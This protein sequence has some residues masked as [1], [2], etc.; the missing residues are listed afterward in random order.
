M[1]ERAATAA[2]LRA[3]DRDDDSALQRIYAH[4]VLTGLASF[5]EIPPDVGEME[6]RRRAVQEDGLPY[7]VAESAGRVLG[8]AY[9]AHYRPRSGYRFTVEDSVYMEPAAMGEGIGRKLLSAVIAAAE[10]AGMRQM[11]AVIGDSANLPS[12]RLHERLGFKHAGVFQAV[13]WKHN[14]WLDSVLMQR[15][16]GPGAATVPDQPAGRSRRGT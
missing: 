15:A 8:F 14:R 16:L 4:H 2:V 5:E 9:A 10:S 3:A 12:I 1:M 6:R 11:I 7:L 13:G